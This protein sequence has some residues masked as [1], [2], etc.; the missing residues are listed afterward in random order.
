[1]INAKPLFLL[2]NWNPYLFKNFSEIAQDAEADKQRGQG[3][4][5][6]AKNRIFQVGNILQV[7]L[8][9]LLRRIAQAPAA[10][11]SAVSILHILN[12]VEI[13]SLN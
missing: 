7:K 4:Q 1:M 8:L 6:H 9:N 3:E 5:A 2:F 11:R 12:I 13:P 10:P